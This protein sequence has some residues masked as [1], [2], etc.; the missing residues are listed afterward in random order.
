VAP[1]TVAPLSS[2]TV[3]SIRP[4][5]NPDC[6]EAGRVIHADAIKAHASKPA[7]FTL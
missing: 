6:A 2:I 5:P 7:S 3:P 1:E 4:L